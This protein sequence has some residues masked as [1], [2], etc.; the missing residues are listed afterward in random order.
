MRIRWVAGWREVGL[1]VVVGFMLVGAR[2]APGAG[3]AGDPRPERLTVPI[4]ASCVLRPGVGERV[5][6]TC[7]TPQPE[8]HQESVT[9]PPATKCDDVPVPWRV[10]DMPVMTEC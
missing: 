7:V 6:S 8:T 10:L 3:P 1:S 5:S 4:A 9:T 2:Q